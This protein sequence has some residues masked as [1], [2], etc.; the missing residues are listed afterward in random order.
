MFLAMLRAC[1]IIFAILSN[2][3]FVVRAFASDNEDIGGRVLPVEPQLCQDMKTHGVLTG[4]G[5]VTCERLHLVI[6]T[7]IDFNGKIKTGGRVIVLDAISRQVLELFN[8]LRNSHFP[9]ERAELMDV[10]HGNDD[11]SMDNNNTSAFNDRTIA[12]SDRLSL[13][14]YGAAIDINPRQNPNI[15]RK[16]EEVVVTPALGA[17]YVQRSAPAAGMAEPAVAIFAR[18]GFVIWG[19]G[20]QNP[21]D[22]QHFQLDRT[23]AEKL[24]ALPADQAREY[25]NKYVSACRNCLDHEPGIG[26][27][28]LASCAAKPEN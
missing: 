9:I 14:A 11:A 5:P 19:G 17:D 15:L 20:W 7:Y 12:G 3:D 27:P 28:D 16:G 6:F 2:R 24:A 13:H 22:Y 4:R 18:H 1:L 25:F 8:E 10:Y 26:G 23:I 21:K